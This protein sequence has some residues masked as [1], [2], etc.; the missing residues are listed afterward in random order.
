M[1]P[2]MNYYPM[3]QN[4]VGTPSVRTRLHEDLYLSLA[5]YAQNGAS[6]T[7]SVIV[8]PMI[9]WIWIGGGIAALGALFAISTGG[10]SMARTERKGSG[11]KARPVE[12]GV[13]G[14]D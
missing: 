2:R 6:A 9:V 4:P 13:G 1:Q 14:A 8:N 10:F 12:A 5:A 3:S 11:A 7:L